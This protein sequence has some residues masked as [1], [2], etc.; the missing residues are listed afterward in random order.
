MAGT[1]ARGE[2]LAQPGG[3]AC[4]RERIGMTPMDAITQPMIVSGG[5]AGADRA[6]LDWAIGHGVDHG[7]WCPRGRRAEDGVLAPVYRLRETGSKGYRAR[8]VRN[9]VDSDAT[10]ILNLGEL[11]GGSLETLRIAER[12]GKPVR[13]VQLDSAMSDRDLVELRG[14]VERHAVSTLNV[15]GPRES[16][17]P[18]IYEATGAL[19]RRLFR[20]P[21]ESGS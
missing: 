19:L 7:G 18:G 17:R 2:A 10:L 4:G 13:V 14:W 12:R 6:A 11:E 15:A 21:V 3:T 9:V 16:K 20:Q 5:Q 8:T 1:A